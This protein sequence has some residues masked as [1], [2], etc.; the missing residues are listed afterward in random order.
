MQR[1]LASV[2]AHPEVLD[3]PSF[4][5]DVGAVLAVE[6][7]A[8]AVERLRAYTGALPARLFEALAHD[9]PALEH[10]IGASAFH[11]LVHR[12]LPHVPAGVY[13]LNEV[14]TCFPEFLAAD[15]IARDYGFAP[16]LARLER[17]I[18]IA[19]HAREHPPLDPA[20]C[21]AWSLEE[22]SA[23]VLTFQPAVAVV[24]SAWPIREIWAAR[25]TPVT[26]IDIALEGRSDR[27]LVH[28]SGDAVVCESIDDH[29]AWALA[30]LLGGGALGDVADGL[31]ARGGDPEAVAAFFARW[32]AR[33]L[34]TRC[35]R[36]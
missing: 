29:E 22:W 2:I 23:A 21:T 16:D 28:R 32:Q 19:F 12:Y 11:E 26:E 7:E 3:D 20:A 33:G 36:A 25:T 1:W 18:R 10:V 9:Y 13:N 17:S 6:P 4:R 35:G 8:R 14:G 24:T 27:V 15:V 30:R 31:V 5:R 34:V